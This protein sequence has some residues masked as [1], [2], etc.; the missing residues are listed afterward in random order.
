MIELRDFLQFLSK[1]F[2]IILLSGG[3]L[4]VSS[5]FFSSRLPTQYRASLL[6]YVQRIP[7]E[8]AGSLY[9]YDGYYAGQAAEAYSDTVKGLLQSLELTRDSAAAVRLTGSES[10]LKKLNR[11]T[12]VTK[13]APQLIEITTTLPDSGEASAFVQA[14]AR[15]GINR[16]KNLNAS[17]DQNLALTLVNSDPLIETIKPTAALNTLVGF[18]SGVLLATAAISLKKY[19]TA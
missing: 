12:K 15:A 9:A 1:R 5:L 4:G 16:V 13:V 2:L 3:V 14:L 6:L 8:T 18:L 7:Q 10:E 11:K 19:P 17:G